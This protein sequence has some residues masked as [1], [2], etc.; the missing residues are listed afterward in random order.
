[1]CRLATGL[2]RRIVYLLD[3]EQSCKSVQCLSFPPCSFL[4]RYSVCLAS[5]QVVHQMVYWYFVSGSG[6]LEAQAD[7]IRVQGH[8]DLASVMFVGLHRH[9]A[10]GFD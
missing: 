7:G 4:A 5:A 8:N 1:L 6:A 2:D 10:N 3:I 9:P